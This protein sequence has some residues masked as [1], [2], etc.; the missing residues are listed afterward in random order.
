MMYTVSK[1]PSRYSYLCGPTWALKKLRSGQP[2]TVAAYGS[3]ITESKGGAFHS[4]V[5]LL[6][7]KVEQLPERSE[8]TPSIL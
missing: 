2:I 6:A 3:S 4:S 1:L 7:S 5:D 8:S